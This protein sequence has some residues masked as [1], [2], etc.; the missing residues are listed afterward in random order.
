MMVGKIPRF[1]VRKRGNATY[2]FYDH[3]TGEDGKRKESPLGKDYG[4]AIKKWA[5]IEHASALPP[6]AVVLFKHVADAYRREVIPHKAPRTQRDNLAELGKLLEYFNDPPAPLD[7][8]QP[9]DVQ[10]YMR[11]RSSAPVRAT[12]EKALL[13]HLWNWARANRYTSLPNPC[14]GIKGATGGRDAYIEDDAFFAIWEAGSPTL[15]DAMDLAY[16]TGQRPSDVLRATDMDVRDGALHFRQAKTGAKVRV[17][18]TGELESVLARI[19]ERKA[20]FKVHCTRLVVNQNGKPI[21]VNAISRHWAAACR[22][23]GIAG[24]QFRDLRAKA[25]TDTEE[26]SGNL[27]DAQRQLG[28]ASLRMTEHY[29]RNRRGAK[30]MPT[31]QTRK[32]S[33]DGA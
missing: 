30:V 18:V 31:G 16:L 4:L 9:G 7:A 8:I 25:A 14:A 1:R 23:A 32:R 24:Y 29:A 3:G 17:E 6:A 33:Q 5:E 10:D 20:E 2:Y 22:A 21:G 19:R 13:S 12:R 26:A 15:R 28:H 11:W 27:R